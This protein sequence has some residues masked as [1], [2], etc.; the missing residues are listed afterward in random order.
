[1]M[2]GGSLSLFAYYGRFAF[3]LHPETDPY[4]KGYQALAIRQAVSAARW[5]G[6]GSTEALAS[7]APY[8]RM[9]PE[10]NR[11]FLLTTVLFKL[12]WLAGLVLLAALV[13]LLVW[14]ML[15]WSRQRS[16]WGRLLALSVIVPFGLQL[17]GSVALNLGFVLTSVHI[18]LLVG[19]LH[20]VM[21]L[22]LLG[23]VLSLFRGDTVAWME[24]TALPRQRRSIPLFA[25]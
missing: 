9:V 2:A 16:Q 19:N 15:R 3:F 12:G 21:D 18:P 20:T 5:V 17:F 11:D 1:M 14:L 22:A 13:G 7:F 4:G 23:L 25:R 10:W 8:E 6:E 24:D